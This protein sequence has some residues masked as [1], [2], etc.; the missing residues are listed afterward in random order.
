[1]WCSRHTWCGLLRTQFPWGMV[2]SSFFK[3]LVP[4]KVYKLNLLAFVGTRFLKKFLLA[5]PH[6]KWFGNGELSRFYYVNST[7]TYE[8]YLINASLLISF[9][10]HHHRLLVL[11]LLSLRSLPIR[12]RSISDCKK[13]WGICSEFGSRNWIL[14]LPIRLNPIVDDS[15]SFFTT[16][17]PTLWKYGR[18]VT[19]TT[20]R[21]S[22]TRCICVFQQLRFRRRH[23][24]EALR[25]KIC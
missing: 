8:A 3:N 24:H 12:D 9:H 11:G 22:H 15:T 18:T 10:H 14:N 1:M 5:M 7:R 16:W 2:T 25:I 21:R 23:L 4:T 6:R 13:I 19:D 20:H 17:V